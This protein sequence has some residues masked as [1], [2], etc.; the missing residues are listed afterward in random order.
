MKEVFW[1]QLRNELD[2]VF[3]SMRLE[4]NCEVLKITTEW[5]FNPLKPVE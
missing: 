4:P 5:P 2:V 3:W 1:Y